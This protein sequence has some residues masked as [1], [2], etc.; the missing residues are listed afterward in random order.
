M[1][2][3][4]DSEVHVDYKNGDSVSV[5]TRVFVFVIALSRTNWIPLIFIV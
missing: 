3:C 4:T 1:Y 5:K 2:A